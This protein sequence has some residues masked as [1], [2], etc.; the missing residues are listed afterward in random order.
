[1]REAVPADARLAIAL[2][3][4]AI[5]VIL[6]SATALASE[7]PS[8]GTATTPAPAPAASSAAETPEP[9]GSPPGGDRDSMFGGPSLCPRPDAVWAE[10]GTLVP[11]DRLDARLRAV[12][13]ARGPV[14]QIF[15]LGVPYRIVAAGRVREYRDETRDCAYRARIAAVFVALAIDPAE[16]S[17]EPPP[18][19]RTPTPATLPIPPARPAARLELAA[20]G[21]LGIGSGDV[22]A[23]GGL[24]LRA[25]F[26]RGRLALVA[27][28]AALAPSDFTVSGVR[29]RQWRLPVDVGLRAQLGGQR[30]QPFAELGLGLALLSERSLSLA[31]PSGGTSLEIGARA[32][33][34]LRLATRGR[35]APFIAIDGE[36]VP[37]PPQV[38]ALPRGV[39]GRTPLLWLGAAI[40]AS[41]GFP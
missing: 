7:G 13:G 39:L 5:L 1:M 33:A 29:L 18:Q 19:P 35:L 41:L 37:S 9:G 15:D 38:F 36:L 25:A 10:L 40:G 6:T 2:C 20:A 28:T 26:G 4:W 12:T 16:L 22:S 14:V 17:I 30:L 24:A 27:G 21:Q 32:G 34:G 8:D 23:M 31:N 11:R 3:G